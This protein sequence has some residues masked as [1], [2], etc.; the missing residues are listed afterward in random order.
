MKSAHHKTEKF[1]GFDRKGEKYEQ[2][3]VG[4]CK[5][6]NGSGKTVEKTYTGQLAAICNA[7]DSG[8]IDDCL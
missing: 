1:I 4:G 3:Q 8:S 2:E 6:G 7:V 5:S